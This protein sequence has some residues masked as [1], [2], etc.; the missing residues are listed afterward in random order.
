MS[1][2]PDIGTKMYAVHEH[3]YYIS[4][5]AGPLLEYCVME[6]EV[7]GFFE[8]GYVEVRLQGKSP[9][10]FMAP[11]SYKLSEVENRV[12]YTAEEAAQL[13]KKMTERYEKSCGWLGPPQ[14]P[15]RRPWEQY[16]PKG[17]EKQ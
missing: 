12:F 4:D 14:I 3:L 10:G 11:Y 15:L 17:A 9:D 5:F 13:A 1:K 2:R 7:T 6:A 16:L 8:G